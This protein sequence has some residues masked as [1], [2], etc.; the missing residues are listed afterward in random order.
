MWTLVLI[1]GLTGSTAGLYPT[2]QGCLDGIKAV[3]QAYQKELQGK[4]LNVLALPTLTAFCF[5]SE[6]WR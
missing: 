5:R 2:E 3:E 6:T 1:I 4:G